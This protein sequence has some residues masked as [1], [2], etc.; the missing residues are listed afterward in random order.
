LEIST[1]NRAADAASKEQKIA[2][3]AEARRLLAFFQ[4]PVWATNRSVWK[5]KK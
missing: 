2:F 3:I 4:D 5:T 1:E